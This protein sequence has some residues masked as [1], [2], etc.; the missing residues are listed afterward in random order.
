MKYLCCNST[1]FYQQD[2]VFAIY[3]KNGLGNKSETDFS[4]RRNKNKKQE[5]KYKKHHSIY[6]LFLK[7]S[8][9][10]RSKYRNILVSYIYDTIF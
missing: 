4:M 9:T 10:F 5:R 3:F 6:T 2:K 8:L 7:K 1:I